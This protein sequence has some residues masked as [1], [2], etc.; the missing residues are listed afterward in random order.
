MIVEETFYRR[1][2]CGHEPRR[3]A[4][5][6]Y[7]L[8]LR[9]LHRSGRGALFVPIRTMQYLAVVDREEFIFVDRAGGRFIDLAWREFRPGERATLEAPVAFEAV[10]Y[11]PAAAATMPR[12]HAE[13]RRALETLDRRSP[14]PD[15][16]RVLPF[17]HAGS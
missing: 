13:F 17:G 4:A 8:A 15:R 11:S 3:L 5:G 6:I 16:T 7:N 12:L 1:T 2:E 14:P 10:Y 9:L